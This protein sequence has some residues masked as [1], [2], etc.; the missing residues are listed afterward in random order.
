MSRNN[1]SPEAVE[2][3]ASAS[4]NRDEIRKTKRKN[5]CSDCSSNESVCDNKRKRRRR[6]RRS[7]SSDS[8]TSMNSSSRASRSRRR[9]M[10]RSIKKLTEQVGRLQNFI[11]QAPRSRFAENAASEDMSIAETEKECSTVSGRNTCVFQMPS[12]T[13]SLKE[14]LMTAP[15]RD[16]LEVLERLQRFNQKDWTN[17]RYNKVIREHLADPGFK[18][19]EV[20]CELQPYDSGSPQQAAIERSFAAITHAALKHREQLQQSLQKLVEWG[21]EVQDVSPET[22]YEKVNELFGG[23]NDLQK[24]SDDLLQITC[25]KRAEIIE[26]RRD[27]ILNSCK[28]K[29]D[30]KVLMQIP[31]TSSHLFNEEALSTQLQ[32]LGGV[33]NCFRPF[34]QAITS[35]GPPKEGSGTKK[36]SKPVQYFPARDSFPTRDFIPSREFFPSRESFRPRGAD[37]QR[38]LQPSTSG[39]KRGG[40]DS[41]KRPVRGQ[42]SNRRY[43]RGA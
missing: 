27:R 43:Y 14:P 25:G 1:V 33:K 4:I 6:R 22:L 28:Q 39:V 40:K 29:S 32:K 31:P 7:P 23:Q 30:R 12:P 8:S 34:P 24:C 35:T 9:G 41:S 13:I 17:V 5:L 37:P 38:Y 16:R 10:A 19:L 3:S 15:P 21:F 20:N 11:L 42:T 26:F 36:A 2:I 18:E